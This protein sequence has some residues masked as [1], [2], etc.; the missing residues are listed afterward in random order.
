MCKIQKQYYVGELHQNNQL[1]IH[2]E[3]FGPET[4]IIWMEVKINAVFEVPRW[5]CF[6]RAWSKDLWN[7]NHFHFSEAISEIA[8][9]YFKPGWYSSYKY[10]RDNLQPAKRYRG[11]NH[12]E[13]N[14]STVDTN[15]W[16]IVPA[17]DYRQGWL[18]QDR[19]N[20]LICLWPG[21]PLQLYHQSTR[22]NRSGSFPSPCM[23]NC[24]Q[25]QGQQILKNDD[26][27]S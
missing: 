20:T 17:G 9:I 19:F 24:G 27:A 22:G 21:S 7:V 11:L 14:T 23:H 1:V 2:M 12:D 26:Q 16:H 8:A 3:K 10:M 13:A 18:V 25:F 15:W 4:D 6:A 5:K